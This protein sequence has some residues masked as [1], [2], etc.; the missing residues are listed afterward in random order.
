M[1]RG[2]LDQAIP[3]ELIAPVAEVLRWVG[4]LKRMPS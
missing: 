3:S 4:E 2:T 1:D